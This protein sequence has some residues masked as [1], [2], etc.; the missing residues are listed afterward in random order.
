MPTSHATVLYFWEDRSV[1]AWVGSRY[2]V[3]KVW[4]AIERLSWIAG[5]LSLVVA[6][7]GAPKIIKSLHNAGQWAVALLPIPFFVCAILL[8]IRF[9]P[10]VHLAVSIV[11]NVS[12]GFTATG[13]SRSAALTWSFLTLGAAMGLCL[14]PFRITGLKADRVLHV[15]QPVIG[16]IQKKYGRD[17]KRI[18]LEMQRLQNVL[19]LNPVL[20]VVERSVIGVIAAASALFMVQYSMEAIAVYGTFAP[21]VLYR[22]ILAAIVIVLRF[23]LVGLIEYAIGTDR[24]KLGNSRGYG[25]AAVGATVIGFLLPL[26]DGR[27]LI[28]IL[29]Y[30][31]AQITYLVSGRLERH[32]TYDRAALDTFAARLQ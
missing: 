5:I 29:G 20:S 14:L 25:T 11:E 27:V 32:L 12:A 22:C 3:A 30:Y 7:I 2:G 1:R 15:A 17:R 23:I 18:V 8:L 10:F 4:D 28:A 24:S 31:I 26:P 9:T 13:L 21:N 16:Q 6:V 19:H